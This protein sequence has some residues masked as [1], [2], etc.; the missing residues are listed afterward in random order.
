[1]LPGEMSLW[2][3]SLAKDMSFHKPAVYLIYQFS[4]VLQ[5]NE[6]YHYFHRWP[7]KTEFGKF[8]QGIMNM[9]F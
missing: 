3:L 9:Y 1:M 4:H 7:D 8:L 6:K 5:E 2:Q